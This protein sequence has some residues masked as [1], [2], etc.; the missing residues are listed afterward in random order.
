MTLSFNVQQNGPEINLAISRAQRTFA[1]AVY[2]ELT[3]VLDADADASLA[4]TKSLGQRQFTSILVDPPRNQ[5]RSF[6]IKQTLTPLSSIHSLL[7]GS[8]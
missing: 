3:A 6:L 8:S 1:R 5:R 7:F 4:V 2:N